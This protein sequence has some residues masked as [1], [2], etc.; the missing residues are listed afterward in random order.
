[1]IIEKPFGYDLQSCQELNAGLLGVLDENQLYRI[2]HYLGKASV[3]NAPSMVSSLR[4]W[5][6]W[7]SLLSLTVKMRETLGMEGRGSYYDASGALRDMFQ[8]HILQTLTHCLAG[9]IEDDDDVISADELRDKKMIVLRNLLLPRP[10]DLVLG[11]YH[12]YT[13]ESGVASN[14]TTETFVSVSTKIGLPL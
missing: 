11:Q 1:V 8:N 14:S 6:Q 7:P 4:R 12:G 10:A 3:V 13:N 9:A 5:F 2:D